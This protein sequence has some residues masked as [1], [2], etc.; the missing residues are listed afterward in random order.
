MKLFFCLYALCNDR[1]RQKIRN[2]YDDLQHM[3]VSVFPEGI[4][5]ELHIQFQSINRKR[6][7]HIKRRISRTEII[8]LDLESLLSQP[9][10]CLYYLCGILCICRFRDFQQH[11]TPAESMLF[12]KVL[13]SLNDI[14]IIHIYP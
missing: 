10:S 13:Q 5:Y 1:H 12:Y 11:I 9:L 3:S 6:R 2:T 8:H 14:R 7:Y 4:T